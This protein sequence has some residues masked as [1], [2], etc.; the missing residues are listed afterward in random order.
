MKD[1]VGMW[2]E[3][4]ELYDCRARNV[5]KGGLGHQLDG[6]AVEGSAKFGLRAYGGR[7]RGRSNMTRK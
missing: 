6:E 5:E 3:F 2:P 7:T 4:R 1:R